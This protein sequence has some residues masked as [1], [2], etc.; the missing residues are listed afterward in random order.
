MSHPKA[1][2]FDLGGVIV[3][4]VGLEELAKISGLNRDGVVARF[5]NSPTFNAYE[6]GECGDNEFTNMLIADFNLQLSAAE[7]KELWN[8]WVQESYIGTKQML[9][10]LR[11]RYTLACLSNTNALHWGHLPT[12]IIPEKYFDFCFASHLIRAAKPNPKSYQIAIEEMDLNPSDIWF[13]DDTEI[14][15]EAARSIGM[16]AHHVD[17]ELGVIPTLKTLGLLH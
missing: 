15:V 12:H 2:L 17:R 11:S 5:A 6:V 1:L 7:A 16:S 9:I 10:E 3:R 13:F 8:S 14:N 4:W